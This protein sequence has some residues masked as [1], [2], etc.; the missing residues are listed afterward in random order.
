M[1]AELYKAKSCCALQVAWVSVPCGGNFDLNGIERRLNLL[2]FW[3]DKTTT[4]WNEI[5][6]K[7]EKKLS[8]WK[9]WIC[10]HEGRQTL[11]SV[12]DSISTYIMYVFPIPE[13]VKKLDKIRG[14]SY[15]KEIGKNFH[16]KWLWSCNLDQDK[17]WNDQTKHD[18]LNP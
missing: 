8:T 11:N 14:D 18:I 7:F 12:F 10:H 13:V 9:R 15:G 16:V 2:P 1:A 17:V 3:F 6:E 4:T 5:L